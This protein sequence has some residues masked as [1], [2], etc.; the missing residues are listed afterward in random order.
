MNNHCHARQGMWGSIS[1]P[2]SLLNEATTK[3]EWCQPMPCACDRQPASHHSFSSMGES[4]GGCARRTSTTVPLYHTPPAARDQE[5]LS[6]IVSD[7]A[8][9]TAPIPASRGHQ[10]PA[11]GH[12]RSCCLMQPTTAISMVNW[13][14]CF[15][16]TDRQ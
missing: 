3:H 9:Q 2:C 11:I 16:H 1:L 12:I 14:A 8:Q 10:S 7:F 6:M 4:L 13:L 5:Y 15:H